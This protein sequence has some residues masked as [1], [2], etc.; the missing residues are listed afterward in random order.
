MGGSAVT[1]IEEA[2]AA[3]VRAQAWPADGEKSSFVMRS[4][5]LPCC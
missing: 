2:Q 1:V 5:L 4:F 3:C